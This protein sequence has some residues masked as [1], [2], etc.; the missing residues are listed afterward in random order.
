MIDT[1]TDAERFVAGFLHGSGTVAE[2]DDG[3]LWIS[4]MVNWRDLRAAIRRAAIL[5]CAVMAEREADAMRPLYTKAAQHSIT[6][7]EAS[8]LKHRMSATLDFAVLYRQMAE[9]QIHD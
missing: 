3:A 5:E 7:S 4:A 1:R 6:W 2:R 9:G 8:R